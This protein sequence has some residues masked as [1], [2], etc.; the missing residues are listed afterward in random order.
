MKKSIFNIASFI[1]ISFFLSGQ[2][3]GQADS[4]LDGDAGWS[5]D[6]GTE[7]VMVYSTYVDE[8]ACMG[9]YSDCAKRVW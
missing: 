4:S 1:A 7:I 6:E 8:G 2:V 5:G 3:F 9:A